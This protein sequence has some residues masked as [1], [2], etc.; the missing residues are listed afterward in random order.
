[1]GGQPTA[2]E[3]VGQA[4]CVVQKNTAIPVSLIWS[5]R[6]I[7]FFFIFYFQQE[8]FYDAA[9]LEPSSIFGTSEGEKEYSYLEP[10]ATVVS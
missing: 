2:H 7:F 6:C 3:A 10:T 8:E 1:M 4:L 9:E 5:D